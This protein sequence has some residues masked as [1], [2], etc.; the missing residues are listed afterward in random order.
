MD[1]KTLEQMNPNCYRIRPQLP[2][3]TTM[4]VPEK[5]KNPVKREI[6][7]AGGWW[8]LYEDGERVRSARTKEEL[9][10]G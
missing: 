10:A 3:R 8:T 2:Q 1:D 9:N 7:R 4:D 6:K 5:P